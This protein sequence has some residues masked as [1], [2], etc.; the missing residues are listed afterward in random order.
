VSAKWC[1]NGVKCPRNDVEK[2]QEGTEKF[3]VVVRVFPTGFDSSNPS[4]TLSRN[5]KNK[6]TYPNKEG[7]WLLHTMDVAAP[8]EDTSIDWSHNLKIRPHK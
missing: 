1:R 8:H 7:K 2:K 5:I 3:G 6:Q 4:A